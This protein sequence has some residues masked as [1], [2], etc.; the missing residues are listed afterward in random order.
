MFS[1]TEQ[2]RLKVRTGGGSVWR[3]CGPAPKEHGQELLITDTLLLK[4]ELAPYSLDPARTELA[5]PH[6]VLKQEQQACGQ[7]LGIGRRDQ[8]AVST[9]R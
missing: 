7:R 5:P 8:I 6:F 2:A 1:A 4:T 3:V 9:L